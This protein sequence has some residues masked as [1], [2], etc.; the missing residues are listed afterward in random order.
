MSSTMYQKNKKI[1]SVAGGFSHVKIE[2]SDHPKSFIS[3][4]NEVYFFP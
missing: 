3:R 4:I 2:Y 1:S